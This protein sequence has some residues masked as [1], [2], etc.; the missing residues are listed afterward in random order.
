MTAPHI[1]KMTHA[2]LVRR[3]ERWLL[4]TKGCGFT[5]RE[6]ASVGNE[7]PDAIGW[8]RAG[9]ISILV[10]CKAT[11]NDFLS[12]KRKFFRRHPQMG[13]GDYRYFMCPAHL[14]N[15]R[16]NELPSGWGLLWVYPG[17]VREVSSSIRFEKSHKGEV[18]LLCSALRR[19]QICGDLEKIYQDIGGVERS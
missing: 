13:M 5:F 16:A 11:R 8:R 2:D 3:A 10:E 19:V 17:Q 15:P 9:Q 7:I 12:D 6:L 18:G 1:P 14:I 4:N